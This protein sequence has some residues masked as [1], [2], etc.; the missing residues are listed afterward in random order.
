MDCAALSLRGSTFSATAIAWL[1]PTR[2]TD[3]PSA[4]AERS[5]RKR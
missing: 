1:P 5:E 2:L 3:P 4:R